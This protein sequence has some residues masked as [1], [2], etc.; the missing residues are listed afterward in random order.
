[1]TV[2]LFVASLVL[3]KI[4]KSSIF[5]LFSWLRLNVEFFL[6]FY[7]FFLVNLL[8]FMFRISIDANTRRVENE[9]II[10]FVINYKQLT[11]FK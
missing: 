1:M 5:F 7:W 6:S 8:L 9:V 4:K 10:M 3:L 2:R 11:I